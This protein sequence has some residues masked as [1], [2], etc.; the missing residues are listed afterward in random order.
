VLSCLLLLWAYV[1]SMVWH[2]VLTA[3]CDTCW[4]Q[5]DIMLA[6]W[7][8]TLCWQHGVAHYVGSMAWHYVGSMAWNIMLAAWRDTLCWQHG[9]TCWQ[10]GMTCWQHGMTHYVDSMVWHMVLTMSH[11]Y[12]HLVLLYSSAPISNGN[13]FQDLLRLCETVDNTERFI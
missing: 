12:F 2:I 8:D 10:H 6:A 7:C 11:F 9:V 4:Q 13:T 5:C 3:W 1:G